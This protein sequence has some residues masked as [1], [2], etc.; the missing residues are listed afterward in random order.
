MIS[1][2]SH[3]FLSRRFTPV[4]VTQFLGAFNDNVYKNALVILITYVLA[5]QVGWDAGVLVM[6][7]SGIFILPFFIFSA[8]AGQCADRFEKSGIIRRIKLFEI[9]F[10]LCAA[11]ALFSQNIYLLMGVLFLTGTQSAFFGPLKYGILPDLLPPTH[12]LKGNGLVEAGTFI[13]ILTGTI[14]GG[15]FVLNPS[16]L[17][18]I[19][20]VL[21]LC[22]ICGWWASCSIP[23]VKIA[24]P[25]TDIRWNIIRET[26]DVLNQARQYKTAFAAAL[27][28]SWFWLVG[29]VFLAQV[30][31]YGE[32]ILSVDENVVTLFLTTFSIGVGIGSMLCGKILNNRISGALAPVGAVG[33]AVSIVLLYAISHA[34]PVPTDTVM[35]WKDFW[36]M[37]GTEGLIISLMMIA[38]FGGIYVVPLY[39]VLQS[40][41]SDDFRAR[42]I[43]ANNILNAAFMVFGAVAVAFMQGMGLTVLDIFIGLAIV[44]FALAVIFWRYRPFDKKG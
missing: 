21:L 3:I 5:G 27:G 34:F 44:N 31:V 10:M 26:A 40:Q 7:A 8:L 32:K 15:A 1:L 30:P 13:A 22:A 16:G 43:A 11:G 29:F 33:M 37:S 38:V 35:H 12:L 25:L 9:L 6:I 41:V 2:S 42:M 18:I 4:F 19:S 28:V 39:T 14:I 23:V 24:A 20:G 17:W 36:R